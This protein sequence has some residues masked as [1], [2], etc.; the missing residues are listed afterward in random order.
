M[1]TMNRDS[2]NSSGT[3]YPVKKAKTVFVAEAVVKFRAQILARVP[4]ALGEGS[5]VQIPQVQQVEGAVQVL[6]DA[7]GT[8]V[9]IRKKRAHLVRGAQ[10]IVKPRYVCLLYTSSIRNSLRVSS[11]VLRLKSRWLLEYRISIVVAPFGC[12]MV[13]GKAPRTAALSVL[14]HASRLMPRLPLCS[15]QS[16][17]V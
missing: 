15:R 4:H 11:V 16:R 7:D 9:V 3:N 2:Q 1:E 5:A 13:S 12:V 10:V 6:H 17:C 8:R 14:H